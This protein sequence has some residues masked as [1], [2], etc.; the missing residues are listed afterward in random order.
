MNIY[1]S[2]ACCHHLS[3]AVLLK[4]PTFHR[5]LDSLNSNLKGKYLITVTATD[6]GGLATSTVLD[7]S[8]VNH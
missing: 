1:T 3:M 8:D 5:T 4:C 6:T 7:V 2:G